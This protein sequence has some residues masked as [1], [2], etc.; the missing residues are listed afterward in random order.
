MS[1]SVSLYI[2][3]LV[4]GNTLGMW[5]LIRWTSKPIQSDHSQDNTTGH[6]WDGDLQEF[7]NPLPRWWLWMFYFTIIF[8]G[9]Y[10]LLFPGLGS[11]KGALGWSST[12][13]YEGEMATADER[14]QPIFAQY[15]TKSVAEV[16]KDAKAQE[17]G[18]RLFVTYC[19]SCHGSDARGALGFPNL[20]DND[21]LWG[22]EADTIKTTILNG[23]VGAMP[24]WGPIL[25]EEKVE[26]VA[27][28]VQTL[29]GREADATKAAA[30]QAVFA[31]NCAACHGIEGKGN[32]L[33][34]APNLTDN[35]WLY[36]NSP[37]TLVETITKGRQGKMP[38]HKDFLGEEKV[39][40]LAAY[41]YSLSHSQ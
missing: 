18:Q 24:A 27:S 1:L 26:Q 40:L 16:A 14:Y 10:L 7:N 12:G 21:W 37:K 32:P 9:L 20:A 33:M 41:V 28:Y 17:M 30:G 3:A 25:G 36:G 13:Q 35:V 23:R 29:S 5:W 39:H 2:I 34:G 8:T 19:A 31:T 22:G 38:A 15:A 11:F 4:V 6:T